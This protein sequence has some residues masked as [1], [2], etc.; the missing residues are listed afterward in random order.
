MEQS[1]SLLTNPFALMLDP[2][3]VLRAVE[4]S[5]KLSSLQSRVCRPLDPPNH[6][7]EF[8]SLDSHITNWHESEEI[9]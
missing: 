4:N 6:V 2:E 7:S 8:D 9:S 3:A 5:E 1:S